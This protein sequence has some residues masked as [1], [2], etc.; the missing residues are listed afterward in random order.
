MDPEEFLR[1]ANTF[2]GL[3]YS[4]DNPEYRAHAIRHYEKKRREL[5]KMLEYFDFQER[6]QA[7]TIE[8][9]DDTRIPR[10]PMGPRFV[11]KMTEGEE[12]Q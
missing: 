2:G 10:G 4:V 3:R 12:Q 11:D 6:R 5:D 8:R 1:H 9:V 7:G